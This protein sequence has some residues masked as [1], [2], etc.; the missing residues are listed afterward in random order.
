MDELLYSARNVE[1][2]REQMLQI[3]GVFKILL[4]L[5]RQFNS[6]MSLEMHQQYK[7]WFDGIDEK[8]MSFKNKIHNWIRD[9][10]HE[11]KG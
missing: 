10:E 1:V 9:A 11:R 6:L 8:I 2:V 7:D 3:D 4:K 5:H